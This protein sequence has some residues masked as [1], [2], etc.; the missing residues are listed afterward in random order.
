[1]VLIT[2]TGCARSPHVDGPGLPPEVLRH[3]RGAKG[4]EVVRLGNI[5]GSDAAGKA[6][7]AHRELL[8]QGR[9][10][11]AWRARFDSLL[12]LPAWQPAT[13][14]VPAPGSH[15]ACFGARFVDLGSI[16]DVVVDLDG[17]TI[18]LAEDGELLARRTLD[19][20]LPDWQQLARAAFPADTAF[21]PQAALPDQLPEPVHVVRATWP[22]QAWLARRSGAVL[23][24]AHVDADGRIDSTRVVRSDPA[25][26]GAALAAVR[27]WRFRPAQAGGRPIGAWTVVPMNFPRPATLAPRH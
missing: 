15:P 22:V 9:A 5:V 11:A 2:C 21:R 3:V 27:Q 17:G 16:V 8:G 25:F 26:D 10:S 23:I 1:M 24:A 12:E 20:A 6:V 19:D 7:F 4:F 13:A 14:T 18:T